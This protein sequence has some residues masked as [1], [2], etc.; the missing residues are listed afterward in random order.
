M[1]NKYEAVVILNVN[2][3]TEETKEEIKKYTNMIQDWCDTK[4]VKVKD[5]GIKKLAY[6]IR[7]IHTKG[8]YLIFTF[9]AHPD[10]ILELERQFRIDDQVIK[11]ITVKIDSA[12]DEEHELEDYDPAEAKSEQKIEQPD[13]LDV[14]LGFAEYKKKEVV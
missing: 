7:E 10:N 13:A 11:F 2:M 5:M 6:P 3:S 4:K 12:T 1:V 9:L 8:Y 14:L